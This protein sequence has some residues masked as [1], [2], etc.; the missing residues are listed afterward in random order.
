MLNSSLHTHSTTSRQ[1]S[2]N[3]ISCVKSG[4]NVGAYTAVAKGYTRPESFPAPGNVQIEAASVQDGRIYCK[5][6]TK[7]RS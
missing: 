6:C 2:I 5:V 7:E 1:D 4:D 3:I